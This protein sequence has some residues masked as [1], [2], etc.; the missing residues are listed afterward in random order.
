M[1][2]RQFAPKLQRGLWSRCSGDRGRQVATQILAGAGIVAQF[3]ATVEQQVRS[4]QGAA[5]QG[6]GSE[7]TAQQG[8]QRTF[9]GAVRMAVGRVEKARI[10]AEEFIAA[11]ARKRHRHV[12]PG[13]ARQRPG[14]YVG[15]IGERLI[16]VGKRLRQGIR[17]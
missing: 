15:R 9:A 8:P 17:V 1:A 7:P 16:K 3:D 10:A 6:G 11:V 5:G 14:G 12:L 4:R 13:Q 2:G